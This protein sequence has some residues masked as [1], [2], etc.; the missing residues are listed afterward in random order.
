[1]LFPAWVKEHLRVPR[2]S[3]GAAAALPGGL[4]IVLG[5]DLPFLGASFAETASAPLSEPRR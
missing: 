1:M 5:V 2:E 3:L 4:G